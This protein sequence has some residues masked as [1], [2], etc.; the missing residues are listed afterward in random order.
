MK[1]LR[2]A[3]KKG[4]IQVK[5]RNQTK[6]PQQQSLEWVQGPLGDPAMLLKRQ[7]EKWRRKLTTALQKMKCFFSMKMRKMKRMSWRQEGGNIIKV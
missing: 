4:W 2:K 3:K 1:R 5:V 7:S 6:K